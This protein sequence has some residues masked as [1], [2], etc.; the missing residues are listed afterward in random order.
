MNADPFREL[1]F[2]FFIYIK[3]YQTLSS[4]REWVRAKWRKERVLP[5]SLATLSLVLRALSAA[6]VAVVAVRVKLRHISV[7]TLAVVTLT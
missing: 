4:V 2:V 3:C 5:P 1:Q 7:T 6:S